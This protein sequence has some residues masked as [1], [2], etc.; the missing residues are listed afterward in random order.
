MYGYEPLTPAS[1]LVR[2]LGG[3]RAQALRERFADLA[4]PLSVQFSADMQRALE[5]AKQC[6]AAARDRMK[7]H[8]DTNRSFREFSVG[9]RV[10]LSTRHMSIEGPRKLYPRFIGP[11]VVKQTINPVAYLLDLP[12]SSVRMHDVFHVSLLRP[13]LDKA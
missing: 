3:K 6:L 10:L 4:N 2:Q 13:Y 8:A 11:F 9:D 12:L 5:R 7:R 1:H